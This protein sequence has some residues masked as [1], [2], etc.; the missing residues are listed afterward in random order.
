[1]PPPHRVPG[2]MFN[3]EHGLF[4]QFQFNPMTLTINKS[5]QYT[6]IPVPGWTE[7]ALLWAFGNTKTVSFRLE[8]ESQHRVGP[9]N[10]EPAIGVR[11]VHAV[12][13]SFL[14]PSTPI[15]SASLKGI[16]E[17][18]ST[19]VE[20]FIP[21]PKAT[22]VFGPNWWNGWISIDNINLQKF[23]TVL[24]PRALECSVSMKVVDAG[25]FKARE[26]EMRKTLATVVYPLNHAV[27]IA[28][29]LRSTVGAT[30]DTIGDIVSG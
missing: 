28:N 21:P 2:F 7:P 18:I 17:A 5:N 11:D 22:F 30:V 27:D 8:F 19:K 23:N 16:K 4:L 25:I 14:Y 9:G 12:L 13:E 1:M 29:S 10:L 20:E 6:S 3:V 15:K 24:T 26:D